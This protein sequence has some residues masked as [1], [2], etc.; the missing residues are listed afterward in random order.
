MKPTVLQSACCKRIFAF[1]GTCLLCFMALF[2]NVSCQ[3]T[4]PNVATIDSEQTAVGMISSATQKNNRVNFHTES[5]RPFVIH[6]NLNRVADLPESVKLPA[7][8][9]SIYR[10]TRSH[11][12]VREGPG[13][14]FPLVG[15][16]LPPDSLLLGF[17]KVGP[18]QRVVQISNRQNETEVTVTQ[19]GWVHEDVITRQGLHGEMA[20]PSEALPKMFARESIQIV[21]E[22]ID[23][24]SRAAEI[25]KGSEAV[26]LKEQKSRRLMLFPEFMTAV[27]VDRNLMD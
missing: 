11:V 25:P 3:A 5:I 2:V 24:D 8:Y 4:S 7:E 21:K 26:M 1:K 12:G 14:S 16:W 18:W 23:L 17:E 9:L 20:I 22:A 10:L 15:D 27:W 6:R 13:M 19:K